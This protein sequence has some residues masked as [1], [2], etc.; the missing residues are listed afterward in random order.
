MSMEIHVLS[1]RR[2]ASMEE[3]QQA[4]DAEGF[5]LRLCD[6]APFDALSGHLPVE[7]A[8]QRDGG[9]ECYHDHIADILDCYDDVDFGG[10]W[11]FILSFRWGGDFAACASAWM[12]AAAYAKA[13][14]G[15]VF[16]PQEDDLFS[17]Q[18][19]LAMARDI[20]HDVPA[21]EAEMRRWARDP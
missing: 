2:L 3:W 19:A 14:G 7:R 12:A 5:P 13:V 10:P 11:S 9:F 16:D 4:I 6:K 15:I 20:D 17:P 18:K 8:D 1:E 21:L